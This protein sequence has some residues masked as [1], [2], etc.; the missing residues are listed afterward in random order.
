MMQ[1]W[2]TRFGEET[3]YFALGRYRPSLDLRQFLVEALHPELVQVYL[4]QFP[5]EL[6]SLRRIDIPISSTNRR[7]IVRCVSECQDS[8]P[9][10]YSSP[11]PIKRLCVAFAEYRKSGSS[12][13]VRTAETMR[14]RR[15]RKRYCYEHVKHKTRHSAN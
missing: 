1:R 2:L 4:G 15:K 13:S 14:T 9:G 8:T 3:D 12:L 7:L 10:H 6:S 5:A 11:R